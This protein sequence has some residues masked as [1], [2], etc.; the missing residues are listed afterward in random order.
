VKSVL[1][2]VRVKVMLA[3][4]PALRVLTSLLMEMLGG[5]VSLAMLRLLLASAPSLLALPA[6]S[7]NLSL[8]TLIWPVVVVPAVG[9]K[10]TW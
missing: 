7:V 5:A 2:L 3:V 4:W 6:A 9:V 1:G 8:V 10:V